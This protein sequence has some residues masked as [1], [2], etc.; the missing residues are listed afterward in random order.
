MTAA[1][2][3]G[4]SGASPGSGRTGMKAARTTFPA[5]PS[6][7]AGNTFRL[8]YPL[9]LAGD[10]GGSR[11]V[12]VDD[13]LFLQPDGVAINRAQMSKFGVGVGEM[14]IFIQRRAP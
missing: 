4:A 8:R 10:D 11:R 2:G 12:D 14:T 9:I 7:V 1:A 13:W 6:V 5:S 3:R